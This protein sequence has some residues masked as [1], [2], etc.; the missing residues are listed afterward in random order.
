MWANS[1]KLRFMAFIFTKKHFII[2]GGL[3]IIV[4]I[5]LGVFWQQGIIGTRERLLF[6]KIKNRP[7]L[8]AIFD[9]VK[10]SQ[11]EIA[12]D[13]E[14]ASAYFD[15]GLYWKSIAEL[16]GGDPFFE[17]SLK[18]YEKGIEKFGQ[19]NILFYL[20]GGKVAERLGDLS[21]AEKYYRQAIEISAADDSGYSAL[22]DLY[23]YKMNKNEEEIL[24]VFEQ[25]IKSMANPIVLIAGRAAYLRRIGDYTKALEDYRTLNENYPNNIGYKEVIVE[26]KEKLE[27]K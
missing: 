4:I 19:K 1:C 14:K 18:V 12:K 26:L 13:P 22:V 9:K 8:A 17:E 3:I 10:K 23:S 15:L 24:P 25:G 27:N 20:N 21:K 11:E 7:D 6:N 5:V 2:F 16:G